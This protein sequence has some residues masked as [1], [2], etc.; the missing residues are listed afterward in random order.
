[1]PRGSL[2]DKSRMV[3]LHWV[4]RTQEKFGTR[5]LHTEGDMNGIRGRSHL[6]LDILV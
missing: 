4:I 6:K 2:Y 1:M 3:L 5:W